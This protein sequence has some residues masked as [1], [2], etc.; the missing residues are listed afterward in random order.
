MRYEAQTLL[1]DADDTLWENNIYF[2]QAIDAF[3]DFLDHS[4]MTRVQVR[5]VL[6]EIESANAATHGYG[7]KG[8]AQNLRQCY[9][10]LAE[11]HIS[12]EDLATV[13]GFADQILKQDIQLLPGVEETIEELARRHRLVLF[14]K[15]RE[16]EQRM[17]IDRSGIDRHFIDAIV[18]PEKHVDAYRNAVDR[19]GWRYDTTWMVGNSPKSDINPAMAVGLNAV[20]IP[21]DHTWRLEH[22]EI[23]AGAGRLIQLA[24][25]GELVE[26][27]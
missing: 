12:D 20:F 26:Y 14:T 18:V 16:E 23:R 10:H 11:R 21:H 7:S 15:G 13:L 2:E 22:Q 4:T 9:E 1:I 3:I 24:R 6:D 5:G 25:F 8:F 17:K 19:L 27:F